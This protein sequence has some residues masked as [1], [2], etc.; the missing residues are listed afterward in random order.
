MRT[1]RQIITSRLALLLAGLLATTT[2][3]AQTIYQWTNAV[4]GSWAAGANWSPA[5]PA[6][7]TDVVADFG[8]LDLT[9][10]AVVTLDGARTIGQLR[11]ADAAPSHNWFLN[12]GSGGPLTLDV[13]AGAPIVAVSNQT[14]TLGVVL[15]GTKGLIKAGRGTLVLTGASTYTGNTTNAGGTLILNGATGHIADTSGLSFSGSSTFNLDNVGASGAINETI[16]QLYFLAG[17]G[18]VKSTRT[19][20]Q[21]VTLTTGYNNHA[22]GS[23][24]NFITAGGVN[25]TDNKI[26]LANKTGFVSGRH[27]FQGTNFV[28]A[29]T[30]GLVRGINY[31]T[32]ASTA[33]VGAGATVGAQASKHVRLTGSITAQTTITNATLNISGPYDFTLASGTTYTF[34]NGLLKAGGGASTFSGG[35]TINDINAE[36][37]IRV[38]AAN[39][40]LAINTKITGGLTLTKAGAG[41]L[42]LG[43]AVNDFTGSIYVD[44][45]T[46]RVG[47]ANVIPFGAGKGNIILADLGTFDVGGIGGTING[48]VGSGVVDNLVGPGTYTLTVGS[49]DQTSAFSGVIRNTSGLLA[50]GKV[51]TGILTLSGSNTF[52]GG[53]NVQNGVV[54]LAH[55]AA[56]GSGAV[57][58]TSTTGQALLQGDG[59]NLLNA[60]TLGGGGY[61]GDGTLKNP[62]GNNTWSGPVALSADARINVTAGSLTLPNL[63]GSF[64]IRKQGAGALILPNATPLTG[65]RIG[66]ATTDAGG[67]LKIGNDASL[68]AG[69]VTFD[70]NSLPTLQSLDGTSHTLASGLAWSTTNAVKFGAAGTGDLLFN[71]S[72][73]LAANAI[74]DI[75]NA[76]TTFSNG[77]SGPNFSLTKQGPGRLTLVGSNAYNGDTVINAGTLAFVGTAANSTNF[78]LSSNAVLDVAGVTGEFTLAS[79]RALR[80]NGTV[81]GSVTIASGAT[82]TPGA[83]IG[84]LV[85][86]SN[87]TLNGNVVMEITKTNS[88]RTNDLVSSAATLTC[89]G[90]LTVTAT[91][92]PLAEGD[93]FKLFN[94]AAY[95]NSF[96]VLNLPNLDPGLS[97]SAATLALD[98]T[99]RVVGSGTTPIIGSDPQSQ[100]AQLCGLV[101][102]SVL[103]NGAPP[104]YCFWFHD[105]GLVSVGLAPSLTLSNLTAAQTGN[106]FLIV[107][108]SYGMATSAVARL[109]LVDT[110]APTLTCPPA[111]T[112]TPDANCQATVPD[113]TAQLGASD[114]NLPLTITQSPAAGTVVG[115]G[116][117]PV[118]FT[119]RDAS[120]NIASCTTT[121]TLGSTNTPVTRIMPL[122]DSITQGTVPGGYRARLWQL[123]TNAGFKVDFVGT[124]SNNTAAT[125]PDPQHE[126]HSGWMIDQI[127]ANILSY[128]DAVDDPDLI[129]L[130][131][132]TNDYKLNNDPTNAIHRLEALIAKIA[133]KRPFAKIVV[134]NLLLRTD[135]PALNDAIQATFNPFVPGV[136]S[137]QA[138]LGRQVCFLDLRSAIGAADLADGLHPNQTGYDKMADSWFSAIT[139]LAVPQG[140][141]P[142]APAIADIAALPT[143]SGVVITFSKPV[144]DCATN[145]ANF[146][147]GGG[148]TLLGATLDPVTLRDVTLTTSLQAPNT[149]YSIT[150][151]GIRDRTATANLVP[152]TTTNFT[153]A[154]MYGP[155][156]NVPDVANYTLL[157]SLVIPN[158]ANFHTNGTPYTLDH[159]LWL[160]NF[161]R[162]AYYVELQ[163]L[164]GPLQYLWIAMDAFSPDA[165]KLGVPSGDTGAFFQQAVANMDV[166]SSVPGIVTG[167]NLNGGYIEFWPGNYAA[168]NSANVPGASSTTLDWGDSPVAGNGYGSMQIHNVAAGQVLFAF[169]HWGGSTV[170]LGIGNNTGNANP[171]WT[172]MANAASYSVKCL[173]VYVLPNANPAPVDADVVVYGGTSGGVAAAVQAARMGKRAVLVCCDNHIGGLSSGGLGQTDTGNTATIGGISREFYTRI[174]QYYGGGIRYT[175]EPHAAEQTYAKML[176]EAGVQVVF[177]QRLASATKNGARITSITMTNGAV[178]RGKMFV[179]TTYEG[180]LLAAAG[181]SFTVGR[182]G[183]NVYGESLNGIRNG[184]AGH[185]F[186]VNVDPYVVPGNPAS[187]LLPFI[188]SGTGGT[189]GD[190]DTRVQAYNF[191]LCLTKTAGN[192][193][194][195]QPPANYDPANYELLGRYLAVRVAHG[196]TLTVSSFMNPSGMPNGKT[197]VNN[198]GAFSSDFIG[199]NY[200]YPTADYATRAAMWQAHED[201][202]RGFLTFLA[203]DSRAPA[204]LRAEMQS[205]ALSLDEFLDTGGWPHA[206]YVREGRRMVSDYVMTQDN[207]ALRR[208]AADSVGLASYN[209]DSHNCQR[210]VQGGYARNEGDVQSAPAGPFQI[211][212]RAIVPRAS[213]CENLFATFALSGS[214]IAFSSCRMEPV[215]MMTSQSAGAAACFAI[216]DNVPV[217]QVNYDKLALQLQVDGQI[218]AFGAT[219]T[220]GLTV[221]NADSTGVAIVGAWT[222][223][224]A[225]AGFYGANYIHDGNVDK[226]TKSVTFTPTLPTNDVYGVYV[227]WPAL[228]NRAPSVPVDIIHPAGTNT[229]YINQQING[230]IWNLVLTT[231][232]TAGTNA[233]VVIRT[234]S[235]TG[236]VMADAVQFVSARGVA[237]CTVQVVATDGTTSELGGDPARV[238][239]VRSG[240][241]SFAVTV[242]YTL[243]GTAS[244]GVDY[245]TLSG[246]VAIPAGATTNS[247]VITALPDSVAE[248]NESIVLTLAPGTGYGIGA[249]SS[250]TVTITEPSAPVLLRVLPTP[251]TGVRSL[252]QIEVQFTEDVAGVDAS[253]LLINGVPATNLLFG[254]PGQFVFQFAPSPAGPVNVAWAVNHGIQDLASPPNP[255]VG[256]PWS[257]TVDPTLVTNLFITEFMAANKKATNDVDGDAS[258]WIEIW[259]GSLVPVDLGGWFLT[260]TATNLTKWAFPHVTLAA[261]GYLLVFAS[262]KNRTD[263]AAQL[264][265][266]FKLEKNTGFLALVAPDGTNIASGFPAYPAQQTDVSY[267]R[268]RL[269]PEMLGYFTTPT[270]GQPNAV[271]GAGFA[272]SVA[273]SRGG[274]TFLDPF[275]LALTMTV[276]N[277][278]AQ[279][280]YT[281]DGMLPSTNSTLYAA[282]LTVTNSTRLRAQVFAPGL[283]P[284]EVRSEHFIRLDAGV[285]DFSSDLPLMILHNFGAG[286]VPATTEQFVYMAEFD[287]GAGGR[288]SLAA[289]PDLDSRGRF[290]VR[291]RSTGSYPKSNFAYEAWD[292]F[293][294]GRNISLCGM[295]EESDWVLYAPD[296]FDQVMLHNPLAHQLSRDMGRY[297]SRTRFVEVFLNTTGGAVAMSNYYGIYVLEEK[298]K[299]SSSRVDIAKLEPQQTTA[300]QG[301]GGYLLKLDQADTGETTFTDNFGRQIIFVEPSSVVTA[302]AAYISNYFRTFETVLSSPSYADPVTGYA[303]YIDVDSWIDH[304]IMQA[305][306]FNVDA[307]RL[308]GYFF[309]DRDKKIEMGP[310][311]DFDRSQGTGG[312]SGDNRA[313]NPRLWRVQA[314]GDQG[315]DLFSSQLSAPGWWALLFRDPDFW[316]KWIDRWAQLRQGAFSTNQIFEHVDELANQLRESQPRTAARWAGQG[317]SSVT[318]RTGVVSANGYSFNFGS[319]AGYQ[320]EIDFLK[321]WFAD[322]VDFLDT[323]FVRPPAFSASAGLVPPS[324]PLVLTAAPSA[325]IYYTLDGSDP[326]LSG[327]G[328]SP[329]ALSAA[330]TLALTVTNNLRVFARAYD[331][332]HDNMTNA[333]GSY[334][335]N[336]LISSHWSGP[337]TSTFVV[338]TPALVVTEIMYHPAK[339]SGD[340]NDADAYE[341]I[342]LRNVGA[343]MLK[344]VGF[345]FT[346]G[347]QFMFLAAN[348]VT[349]LA[350]GERVVLVA[351]VAAFLSRYPGVTNVAGQYTGN[352][353]NAGERLVLVGPAAEIVQDF[354]YHDGWYPITD[355]AGFSLVIADDHAAP[356]AWNLKSGWRPSGALNGTPGSD[357]PGALAIAPVLVNEVLSAP[358]LPA[359]DAVELFNPAATNVDISGWFL[360]DDFGTP[361]KFRIPDGTVLPPHGYAVFDETYFNPG[362]LGFAFDSAGDQVWLFSA[363]AGG[364]LSGHI[365]GF[366]FGAEEAGVSFGRYRN[367]QG[368][369]HFVA[370]T[371][372][373]LG[374]NNASPLVGPV[375]ISEFMYHPLA[376]SSNDIGAVEFIELQNLT[377]DAVTL[378]DPAHPASTW[379]LR[380]AVDFDFPPGFTLAPRERLLVVGFDPGNAL[381]LAAFRARY[382]VPTNVPILGPW[383]GALDNAGET[384][385]LRK[386][387]PPKGTDTPYILVEEV[388]YSNTAPWPTNAD[389]LGS[390]LQRAML[391]AYANDPTNWLAAPPTAG[392][393]SPWQNHVPVAQNQF[394]GALQNQAGTLTLA[395]LLSSA[396]DP[397]GDPLTVSAVS[398]ASTNGGGVTL[399]STNVLYQPALNFMGQ[400]GFSYTVSDGQGGAATASVLVSVVSGAGYNVIRIDGNAGSLMLLFSGLPYR[401]YA[402]QRSPNLADWVTLT[403]LPA[404]ATGTL[405]FQDPNPPPG[406]AFYR[407]VSP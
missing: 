292:E 138:A 154:A 365:H 351:N 226:G 252:A 203:T 372:N 29:D 180:D 183:T 162:V 164:N 233:R 370:Q 215:F 140:G 153:S 163:Q 150:V 186:S 23:A 359:V 111:Q 394:L 396:S 79:G 401:S 190:G 321:Q 185:Q 133:T 68:G 239:F 127:D 386:P 379:R 229:V 358:V 175:F 343:T 198:N 173:L 24:G 19:E 278:G 4:G 261:N 89:G 166:R 269:H 110:Q 324:Y 295:P 131:L 404:S 128:L 310:N 107:S 9:A 218:L 403:N 8:T 39:D 81:L 326:R 144:T 356:D 103:L 114:C 373:T 126:G 202:T 313:F 115:F 182:E 30:G 303:A 92:D 165:G 121:V 167:T 66:L 245:V 87:L 90:T 143:R 105:A 119:V 137:N 398:P 194:P 271:S 318:P 125:L 364:H 38:D 366:S 400:D 315:T 228:D 171:D 113:L 263:P 193:L 49:N 256:S 141:L 301:T 289:T 367:S 220:G 230:G 264:H 86:S 249:Q 197:D 253:D 334:G 377:T 61:A 314:T 312:P 21:T 63:S 227:R 285:L 355:G 273:F 98:N 158:A 327:G 282:P 212:Y 204:S 375:V 250:A 31:G 152:T 368:T 32:D 47:A 297:S 95:S 99:L 58:L 22:L 311:W 342:E 338:Q 330:G 91:G 50:L 36:L 362:G 296:Y 385:E 18:T 293:D 206:M 286:A 348:A 333:V 248:G 188:Q 77:V 147:L 178:F 62:A 196:D 17:E 25:G 122:G 332:T 376:A 389:G 236:Y 391:S 151:S 299:R 246:S 52:S 172:F 159:H 26:I 336:P 145:L 288:S 85:F 240:D 70:T 14:G 75:Q 123:L 325:T 237:L 235:T 243:G 280:Y 181:V 157:Y 221:D 265:T 51:G 369:E 109:T 195:I 214:H 156:A 320:V 34:I 170:D 272:G 254:I 12:T 406:Q 72:V 223:S 268:D 67:V 217:Q 276:S 361:N 134:A 381:Q 309:K 259:N 258:D 405:G 2:G 149:T 407:T 354:S 388:A 112:L 56:A 139:K 155:A 97:W 64:A 37:P 161:S 45:G 260:D 257:Y 94:A 104:L 242:N 40:S 371:A 395:T 305:L 106:Y 176:A 277:A 54:A 15:A 192:Q 199:M 323:N 43:S 307:F 350:P 6:S 142:D 135:Y 279:I 168:T 287:P 96:A 302:Q 132:G 116:V 124:L 300:P 88:V 360:T 205:W 7:G 93:A 283:W 291:G 402:I 339:L 84:R 363:D 160:S 317:A 328:V 306:A 27:A 270:P 65:L 244:N 225:T 42:S 298:I 211:S 184:A 224:T 101:T 5:G 216:D 281:L 28:W 274:G 76:N 189:V 247:V 219:S 337:S 191:R 399:T 78:V 374:T 100:T 33:S 179:D 255:F 16:G 207:C 294:A 146:N 382:S 341:F 346:N 241:S 349:S 102:F 232:F 60:A 345:R 266:N 74:A 57:T 117:T 44:N 262:G 357:D 231:N 71:G 380:N 208:I 378:F 187:G 387:A 222:S 308:S 118:T 290:K 352:L 390:S 267:G 41:L 209:M 130:L 11:F 322:R 10:N 120:N 344:L 46:L 73:T 304:H 35:T 169:N 238:T 1:K 82:L 340:T 53:V 213:E 69:L 83:S 331:A 353:D 48:L 392:A 251:G 319:G 284:G 148:L 234:D 177:K 129:L 200:D 59:L 210:I 13:S 383:S 136:V 316:Q 20:A 384:I 329:S 397:D 55:N 201:Y 347:I 335:G 174:G 275:Q 3:T 80:G 108:N 393:I